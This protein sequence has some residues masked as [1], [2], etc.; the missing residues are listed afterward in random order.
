MNRGVR[1]IALVIGW[2]W[3]L[4]FVLIGVFGAGLHILDQF[5]LVADRPAVANILRQY[6]YGVE[7][8]NHWLDFRNY[9]VSRM[10]H[11]VLGILFVLLAPV[12]FV[13]SVRGRFPWL[14]RIVGVTCLVMSVPLITTGWIFAFKYTYTGLPEQVPTVTFTLIYIWLIYMALKNLFLGNFRQHREW[15]VRAFAMMMGI[16]AT[17]VWFYIFLQATDVPSNLFFSSIFWLGLGVN[18]LIAEI[19]V[20]LTREIEGKA[21]SSQYADRKL[22]RGG[23]RNNNLLSVVRQSGA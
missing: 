6:I 23:T 9:P 10:V 11:M 18:L 3:V 13:S 21:V 15:M 22:A 17:R 14:H 7:F 16:S 1:S 5:N 2:F 4:I 12:Q 8:F 20:N 19:W